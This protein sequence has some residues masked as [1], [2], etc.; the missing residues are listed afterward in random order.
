MMSKNGFT[1]VEL[2]IVIVVIA[3]LAAITVTAYNG[4]QSRANDAAVRSDLS[5]FTKQMELHKVDNGS[6]PTAAAINA[7]QGLK[8]TKAAYGIDTQGS[9]ARYCINTAVDN[10]VMMSNSKSGKYYVAQPTGVRSV[11]ATYGWGVCQYVGLSETN[12]SPN[13]YSD[14]TWATW[15][16]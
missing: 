15:A 12:P 5:N 4:I 13:G 11:G 9:N 8:F 14:G 16:N 10:Y 7:M 3:I 6:Y 1:I 2:L